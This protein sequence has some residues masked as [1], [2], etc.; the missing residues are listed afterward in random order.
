MCQSDLD[1]FSSLLRHIAD[2]E[3]Q[4]EILEENDEHC[5]DHPKADS[6]QEISEHDP[7]DRDYERNKLVRTL[8]EHL[9]EDRRLGELEADDE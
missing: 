1:P 2:L 9:F 3:W 5:H 6:D 4:P 8:A 7:A